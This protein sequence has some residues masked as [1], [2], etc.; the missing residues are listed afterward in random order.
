VANPEIRLVSHLTWST[1]STPQTAI[2]VTITASDPPGTEPRPHEYIVEVDEFGGGERVGAARIINIDDEANPYVVSDMRLAVHTPEA[3]GGDQNDDPGEGGTGLQGYRAHYCGVPQRAEP[4]IV[5]C[6]MIVSGLRVF[7]IRDP[8]N[9]V[10]IAYMNVPPAATAT[11]QGGPYAMSQPAFVPER[12][13]I[14][15]S[16]GNSGFFNVKLTNGVWPFSD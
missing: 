10:E 7:D 16:D 13:E 1:V 15:Y 9:P 12:G 6:S 8:F 11:G 14:W 5:A 4:G 2:P 3:Q